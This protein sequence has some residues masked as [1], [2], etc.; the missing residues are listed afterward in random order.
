VN[1]SIEGLDENPSPNRKL[2]QCGLRLTAKKGDNG[3]EDKGLLSVVPAPQWEDTSTPLEDQ[4]D[5]QKI[6]PTK[7]RG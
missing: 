3:N 1:V 2:G 5:T 6:R 4:T 7:L